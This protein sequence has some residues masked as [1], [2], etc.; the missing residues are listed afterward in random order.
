[1]KK[2]LFKNNI[3]LTQ[4]SEKQKPHNKKKDMNHMLFVTVWPRKY[5]EILPR[6]QNL[7]YDIRFTFSAN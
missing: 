4:T 6:A 7:N 5:S 1:M 2:M 3:C